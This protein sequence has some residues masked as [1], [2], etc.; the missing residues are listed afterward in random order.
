MVSFDE[1]WHHWNGFHAAAQS[2]PR[3]RPL[4][5]HYLVLLSPTHS[6]M[7]KTLA[8]GRQVD[9]IQNYSA[10]WQQ[11][12]EK[13]GKEDTTN[14]L[15]NYQ[16]VVNGYYDGATSLYEWGWGSCFHFCRFYKGEG[17]YQAVSRWILLGLVLTGPQLARHE[18]YLATNMGLKRGMRVLD[19]GCGIGGPARE[20]AQFLDIYIVGLNNNDYQI[21]RAR[22][23]TAR[24]GLSDRVTFVKGD[25]MKL[26]EQFGEGSFD[27]GA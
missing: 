2:C 9:R 20:M 17:F 25:F 1:N 22:S 10:F 26:S 7:T 4:L 18:H 24:A 27:A 15:D 5:N 23:L 8:D 3:P 11:K 14:R 6:A 19:V 12:A 13:D 21:G 16:N